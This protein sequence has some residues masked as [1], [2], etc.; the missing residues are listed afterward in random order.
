MHAF[1]WAP[2]LPDDCD[3]ALAGLARF[4]ISARNGASMLILTTSL[5]AR[6]PIIHVVQGAPV[7]ANAT[8]KN[9]A[10]SR[11][12]PSTP[13]TSGARHQ[14]WSRKRSKTWISTSWAQM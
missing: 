2:C 5:I 3:Q 14:R 4:H 11:I 9:T 1:L 8:L 7:A 6:S 13:D 12:A 10:V